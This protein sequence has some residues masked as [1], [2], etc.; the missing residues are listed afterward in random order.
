M[1]SRSELTRSLLAV[2]G[3][4]PGLRPATPATTH[5]GSRVPWNLDTIAVGIDDEL[6]EIRVVALALPLPPILLD[7]EAALHAAL[8]ETRWKDARLRLVVTDI[9]AAA[10]TVLDHA[11]DAGA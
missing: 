3:G 4:I 1:T 9:D 8:Q 11:R 10:L 7:A 5:V 6:I 2:L